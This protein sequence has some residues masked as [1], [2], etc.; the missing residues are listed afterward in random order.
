MCPR[1]GGA[2]FLGAVY[3]DR[4]SNLLMYL[5]AESA[6]SSEN[7]LKSLRIRADFDSTTRFESFRPERRSR[8]AFSKGGHWR[9]K[10]PPS[11]NISIDR[12]VSPAT[13]SSCGIKIAHFG[14]LGGLVFA[15]GQM[16]MRP[17]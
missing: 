12:C 15:R 2:H 13:N 10:W 11:A 17:G 14:R 8:L 9:L 1:T 4:A 3:S 6:V 16:E 7:P 5:G